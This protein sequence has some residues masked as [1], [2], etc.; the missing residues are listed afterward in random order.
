MDIAELL[1][2]FLKAGKYILIHLNM[3]HIRAYAFAYNQVQD[4]HATFIYGCDCR[5]QLFFIADF[6]EGKYS[7][8]TA[9]FEEVRH[10]YSSMVQFTI[11]HDISGL[12]LLSLNP[13]PFNLY[14][15]EKWVFSPELT[16]SLLRDYL[17]STD[18]YALLNLPK[19]NL[20]CGIGV[21]ALL[22][23][24]LQQ[25]VLGELSLSQF[26]IKPFHISWNHKT[27]M[28]A[29]IKYM[30]EAGCLEEHIR[31]YE[32]YQEIVKLSFIIRSIAL[33]SFVTQDAGLMGKVIDHL[34]S[35]VEKETVILQKLADQIH[36]SGPEDC[37]YKDV[38]A[39]AA[40]EAKGGW[41]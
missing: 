34:H 13:S 15:N 12:S 22:M 28:L 40:L 4:Y 39:A 8:K 21:Y 27:V 30:G 25:L 14:E 36:V 16:A 18:S 11:E 9:T 3:F 31:F 17:S 19:D 35:L 7:R 29:R 26:H 33:K 23:E 10:A 41:N 5:Q 2:G 20:I 6:F 32:E 1:A 37:R 38:Q 24:N